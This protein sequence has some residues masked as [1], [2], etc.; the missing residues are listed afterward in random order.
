MATD[1]P[2]SKSTTDNWSDIHATL[3]RRD[4]TLELTK[5]MNSAILLALQMHAMRMIFLLVLH[6]C[7]STK[8][9][10]FSASDFHCYQFCTHWPTN[11]QSLILTEPPLIFIYQSNTPNSMPPESIHPSEKQCFHF[12]C[13][14]ISTGT[15]IQQGV[16]CS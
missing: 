2:T 11:L 12:L 1:T 10:R 8:F 7:I 6:S 4:S 15:E 14:V 3:S 5:Q 16:N 9:T 13:F